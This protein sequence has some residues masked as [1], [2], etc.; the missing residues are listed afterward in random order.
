GGPGAAIG[1]YTTRGTYHFVS[2]PTLHPP[3]IR[4]DA[5]AAPQALSPGYILT[6][7]FYDLSNGPIVGQS[8]PMILDNQFRPVWFR[9]VPKDVVASNLSLQRYQGEPVLAWWQGVVT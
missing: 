1:A 2:R 6:A 5:A 7:N 4:L 3:K 8:G 9:P